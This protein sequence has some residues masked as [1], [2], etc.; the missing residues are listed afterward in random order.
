M[1]WKKYPN[2]SPDEF[3]CR[4]TGKVEMDPRFMDRLQRLRSQ[5][6]RPMP[7]SSGYRHKTH[8]VEAKKKGTGTHTMGRACDVVVSGQDAFAL[9]DMAI[10]LGFT[11]I[12]IQQ[13]GT[14]RFIHLDD[15]R[16]E[17]GFLRPT[18]WS[19]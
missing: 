13:K 1:D 2:F 5:Y 7:I 15:L 8:P 16:E 19:Y 14:G 12:G 11:G 3:K 18:I 4:H 10:T 17:D 9:V 6:G